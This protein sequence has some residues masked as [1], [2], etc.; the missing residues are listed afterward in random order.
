M[1]DLLNLPVGKAL[2]PVEVDEYDCDECFFNENCEEQHCISNHRSDGKDVIYK[3]S[4]IKNYKILEAAEKANSEFSEQQ[5]LAR[6]N[7]I[8]SLEEIG[9]ELAD[10]NIS[11]VMKRKISQM[12]SCAISSS[13]KVGFINGTNIQE[14][15]QNGFI[16]LMYG[17]DE[18]GV[19]KTI[20]EDLSE[21]TFRV[22]V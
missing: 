12:L 5:E 1:K 17:G 8:G 14:F 7:A 22:K 9:H 10:L 20:L 2:V 19:G 13:Y 3:V 15:R 16:K 11:G 21:L 6:D 18:A 4:D